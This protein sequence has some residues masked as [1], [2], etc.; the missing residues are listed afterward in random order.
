MMTIKCFPH[1]FVLSTLLLI[2]VSG[3][4]V[5]AA[6]ETHP[7]Y[8]R[9]VQPL[10]NKYCSGC[11]SEADREA[12]FSTETYQSLHAGLKGKPVLLAGDPENSLLIRLIEKRAEPGMPPEDEPQP[13]AGDIAVLRN[14]I[15][16]GAAG[17]EG[18]QPDRLMLNVPEIP[19]Y[20]N[21]QPVTALATSPTGELAVG[22]YGEVLI[23]PVPAMVSDAQ[24][25]IPLESPRITI[26]E[27]P[28]KIN[29]L[30]FSQD[31]TQLVVASGVS[32]RGGWVAIYETGSG[33]Q[34]QLYEGHYDT[35]FD[36]QLS[37]DGNT[38]ATS[39][40][41]KS[42]ILWETATGKQ[43]QILSGHNG[44]VYDVAFSPDG[45]LLLSGSADDTCKVWRVADGM[46]LDTLGQPLKEVYACLFSPAGD[47]MAAVGADKKLRVW[48]T[49]SHD[50]PKINPQLFA[51]FAHEATVSNLLWT[52]D[53]QHLLTFSEDGVIKLWNAKS[54]QEIYVWKKDSRETGTTACL[55][56]DQKSFFTGRLDGT[57]MAYRIPEVDL[58]SLAGHQDDRDADSVIP[59]SKATVT[60]TETEPNQTPE[61]ASSVQIPAIINGTIAGRNEL[62]AD[63]DLYRIHCN[64]GEEWVIETNA[65]RSKSPLDTFV[66][67]LDA[68]GDKLLRVNLQAVRESYF[69]FRGKN[70]D[71]F[72]DF[73]IFN[74]TE[75]KLNEY[76]YSNGE[77]AKLYHYPR[78]ADSGFNMYPGGGNRWGYFDTTPLSHALNEPCYVVEPFAPDETV[79]PNGL[80]VFPVYYENDDSSQRDLGSDS[81]LIFTAPTDGYYLVKISDVRN[82][83]GPDFKYQLEIRPRQPDFQPRLQTEKLTLH[84]GSRQEFQVRVNRKDDYMGPV[85]FQFENLPEGITVTTPLIVEEGQI[86]ALGVISVAENAE[87]DPAWAGAIKITA[88][89]DILGEV[90]THEVNGFKEWKNGG[91]PKLTLEIAS[92]PRSPQPISKPDDDTLEFEVS[93]GE[94]IQLKVIASR[95]GH[96]GPISFGNEDSGRN[97]PYGV[98]VDNIGL[99]GL[100]ITDENTERESFITCDPAAKPQSRLFH[101]RTT[102]AGGQTTQPVRIHV[103]EK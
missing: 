76:L 75:M 20:Q 44:S 83:E 31:G 46:R 92:S 80:P 5:Q 61:Q 21:T 11:H 63:F 70:S 39:S 1:S 38:L 18:K 85:T 52:A 33:K 41:D 40:Y 48:K 27:I 4:L 60:L 45:K 98:Y 51:R 78:G 56:A 2:C 24:K 47:R 65:A 50:Q 90:R 28:G 86:E 87:I 34:L 37:P 22:R 43:L 79:I 59:E 67:V 25:Q 8:L 94:T 7:D 82:Y 62:Q 10:F 16:S 84:P 14:W 3:Q 89:A 96:K 23:L 69:T 29:S 72:N 55:S 26:K 35:V 68:N 19:A 101:L 54:V 53:G 99:N 15:E 81:R 71:Q 77:V 36:A 74:W 17:P 93:P 32:G 9:D 42:I 6:D 13:T 103:L 88:D 97:L 95:N 57:I 12:D 66:E 58:A 30:S 49:V 64:A 102:A 100:L 91:Q 73:R